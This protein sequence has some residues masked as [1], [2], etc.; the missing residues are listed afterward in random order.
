MALNSSALLRKHERFKLTMPVV[1]SGIDK[2]GSYF[3]SP[4]ETVDGSVEG[5]GLL[6]DRELYP[7][8]SILIEIPQENPIVKI[9]T[10]VRHIT[11]WD[12]S[13][14]LVGVRYSTALPI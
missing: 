13:R 11:P 2:A 1:V 7:F 8:T 12:D 6:L 4:A 5:L 9:Q 14:T 10:E 3:Q